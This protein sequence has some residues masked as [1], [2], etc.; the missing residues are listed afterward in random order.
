MRRREEPPELS[1]RID[2]L[3]REIKRLSSQLA[4]YVR[5][6]ENDLRLASIVDALRRIE[7]E[8]TQVKK[9][10][11]EAGNNLTEQG[12]ALDKL[13]IRVLWGIVSVVITILIGILLAYVTHLIH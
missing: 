12:D 10:L 7:E 9:L 13:Q 11:G 2:M 3:D 8:I 5:T 6:S 4:D 1:M